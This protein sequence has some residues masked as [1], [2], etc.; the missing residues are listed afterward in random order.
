M[1][2]RPPIQ[3]GPSTCV[4]AGRSGGCS[5][6]PQCAPKGAG[7]VGRPHS[8]SVLRWAPPGPSLPVAG[9]AVVAGRGTAHRAPEGLR[10]TCW[11]SSAVGTP[12]QPLPQ[13]TA[14]G[15]AT[16]PFRRSPGCRPESS[17]RVRAA[18]PVPA[19]RYLGVRVGLGIP[20]VGHKALS[21]SL[22]TQSLS[23]RV[24]GGRGPDWRW[25]APQGRGESP[26]ESWCR[27]DLQWWGRS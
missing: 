20:M 23:G 6:G 4:S 26:G 17:P 16:S 3:W 21:R 14:L 8:S 12:S 11:G 13:T 22:F 24:H 18:T 1:V 9:V 10:G 15:V 2:T 7:Q 5:R 25:G 27:P 19:G